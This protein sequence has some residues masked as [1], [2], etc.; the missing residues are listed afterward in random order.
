MDQIGVIFHGFGVIRGSQNVPK[1]CTNSGFVNFGVIFTK[2]TWSES[3]VKLWL[4][5]TPGLEKLLMISK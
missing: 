4:K 1:M 2:I 3:L 5:I